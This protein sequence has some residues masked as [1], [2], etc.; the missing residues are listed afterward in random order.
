MTADY[1]IVIPVY[2][3]EDT[4][5]YTEERIRSEVFARYP[6]KRG[7]I[8]FVDDGSKDGSFEVLEKIYR[9]ANGDVRVFRLS[10]NFG[11]FNATW[12]GL[13]QTQGPCVIMAADGQDSIEDVPTMLKRHFEHGVEIVI[14][15]RYVRKE[16]FMRRASA[17]LVYSAIRRFG[18]K[19]MPE[20]GFDFF[21]IGKKAKE[22]L[23][24]TYQPNTF[25]SVRVLDLGFSREFI[26]CRR[27]ERKGKTKSRWTISKKLTYMIDG[28]LGHSYI[29]IRAI[30]I[31]GFAFS[32]LSFLA[33]CVFF[34]THFFDPHIVPGWTTLFLAIMFTGGIQML[35][36]GV[37]GEYLWRILAQ[38]R[39][40]SPYIIESSLQ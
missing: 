18:N 6:K 16:S 4:L 13:C 38:V 10:R 37:L 30:S 39:N 7:E 28:I 20:G 2:Y 11:Q 9:R 23:L 24:T 31:V 35:M 22:S 40:S 19:D 34:V 5:E 32:I 8:V 21:L 29:P 33:S 12:C 25:F 14:G 17:G 36:I 1:S 27:E 26:P 15:T 3:N